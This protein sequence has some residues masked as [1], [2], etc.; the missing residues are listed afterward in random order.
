M[1]TAAQIIDDLIRREGDRFTDHPADR[2]GPTKYGITQA[3]LQRARRRADPR[4]IVNSADVEALTEG[5]ARAIYQ[6]D[7]ILEPGFDQVDDEALRAFLVD[8]TVQHGA[9]DVVP[10]LQTAVGAKVDGVLGPVTASRVNNTNLRWLF[11]ELVAV[12]CAYYG[13]LITKD[14]TLAVAKEAGFRLQAENAH[15]WANRLAEFIRETA[16]L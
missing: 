10:W 3:T 5:E 7:F 13:K 1:K 6:R 11:A 9:D 12:R 2:G 16:V 15:G 14:P 8:A 4:A